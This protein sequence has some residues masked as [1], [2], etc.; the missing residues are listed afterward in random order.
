MCG[1]DY[2]TNIKNY[3]PKKAYELLKM[4]GTINDIKDKTAVD[5]TCLN[6][7]VCI[8]YLTP[9]EIDI[10]S[11]DLNVNMEKFKAQGKDLLHS[12]SLE[13]NYDDL[14]MGMER[15]AVKAQ[16]SFI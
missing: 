13:D 4:Y 6:H 1:C 16:I 5:V 15:V 2:N 10:H 3:G 12:F 9:K 14:R 11:D 7:E 8:D